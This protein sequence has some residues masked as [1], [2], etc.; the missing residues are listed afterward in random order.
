MPNEEYIHHSKTLN[1]SV[2]DQK[3]FIKVKDFSND[4]EKVSISYW[5]TVEDIANWSADNGHI[6]AKNFGKEH[7]Y[8]YYTVEI[9]HIIKSY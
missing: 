8:A 3:G 5:E 1:N 7:G 6:M 2:K 9:S 4:E